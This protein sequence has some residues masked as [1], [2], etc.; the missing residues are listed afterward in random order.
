MGEE[1]A[2]VVCEERGD[3]NSQRPRR[4]KQDVQLAM[5][6]TGEVESAPQPRRA[7]FRARGLIVGGGGEVSLGDRD[8]LVVGF[9]GDEG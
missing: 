8:G 5:P 6:E 4:R 9:V 7:R 2:E 3:L 1:G